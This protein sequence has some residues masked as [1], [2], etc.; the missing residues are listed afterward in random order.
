[1]YTQVAYAELVDR[2]LTNIGNPLGIEF[3]QPSLADLNSYENGK[4]LYDINGI[5]IEVFPVG[6]WRRVESRGHSRL[7]LE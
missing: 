4:W 3:V 7:S 6:P 1:M 5:S 2:L